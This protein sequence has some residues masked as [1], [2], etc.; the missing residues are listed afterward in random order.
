MTERRQQAVIALA[1]AARFASGILMGTALAVYVGERGSPL[2]VSL[3]LTA[4]FLG[5]MVFAPVWGA[6]ADVTGR[7]RAVLILSGALAT[8]AVL[9]LTIAE[10]V[11]APIALRG[12]YAVFAAGFAPVM[13]AIVSVRGGETGRGKSVG[14]FNSARAVGF[15]GGQL[16]VGAL[17]GLLAPESLFLVIAGVSLVA[18]LAVALV[19]DPTPTREKQPSLSELRREIKERL[20]PAAGERG[21]L[22]TNGLG[23]LYIA[24]ALRNMTVL[25]VMS[26]MPPY[27][28]NHVG[29]SAF[30]M[31][32]LLAINPAGQSAFM[33]AFGRV[34][35]AAGRKPLI[36]VGMAGSGLFAVILGM[37]TQPA[38][39]LGRGLVAGVGMVVIAAAFSAMTT[40]AV[41]FIGDVAPD[42]RESE[43]MG[44][45][46][47]A[48]GVGGVLGPPIFGVVATVA[49]YET[50]FLA[51]SVLAFL[52]AG[53]AGTRLAESR[54]GAPGGVA[55]DD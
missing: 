19:A 52:A 44:L 49:S 43:L 15:A 36:V 30:V 41:A 50:A 21:H 39:P 42:E 38:S 47:T 1:A 7:R 9:P 37:A 45:R 12:V 26:L 31:G 22:T 8:I 29:V 17:L 24:L 13:L 11:V 3:V 51:G 34:A 6:L 23:W 55:A 33:L 14:F 35:D 5:M 54:T 53:V 4:Y 32:A 25:G 27:L 28:T 20:F 10:G 48:K 46:T 2:A 40:G 16:T 18:T